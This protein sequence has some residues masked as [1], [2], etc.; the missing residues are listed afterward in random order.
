MGTPTTAIETKRRT[1][2]TDRM[3]IRGTKEERTREERTYL[4]LSLKENRVE[5]SDARKED[6]LAE[7]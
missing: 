1:R 7:K 3:R 6:T 2:Q 4:S 5:G